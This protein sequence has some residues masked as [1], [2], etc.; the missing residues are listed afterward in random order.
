MKEFCASLGTVQEGMHVLLQNSGLSLLPPALAPG[1][2][3]RK[4]FLY[5]LSKSVERGASEI[6]CG[7]PQQ[8]SENTR[9][10]ARA[11]VRSV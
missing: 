8:T 7:V 5:I 1:C 3:Y 4:E 6:L 11:Q 2:K 9:A 10:D